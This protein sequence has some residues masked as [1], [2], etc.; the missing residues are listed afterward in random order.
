MIQR[1]SLML[2]IS[3]AWHIVW[4][5]R[6]T[7]SFVLLIVVIRRRLYKQLPLFTLHTFWIALA[8]LAVV[9][10]VY[11]SF[12][13]GEQYFA[14]IVI[15]NG[16]EAILAFAIIYQIFVQ[17]VSHYPRLR[18]WGS[19][20][21]RTMT[22]ILVVTAVALAWLVPV[23]GT[24]H[25]SVAYNVVHRTVRMLQCG[26]LLFFFLF[27]GY[28]RLSWRSRPFGIALGF[29]IL[30]GTSLAINAIRAQIGSLA[31]TPS[32][33]AILLV[34]EL[35]YILAIAVWLYYLLAR[36]PRPPTGRDGLPQHDLATWNQELERMLEP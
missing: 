18:D 7:L 9:A 23:P 25:L 30:S 13:S 14:A 36:D 16:V 35:T 21:F 34:S 12:V 27:C 4:F 32:Q 17:R 8:G 2:S 3:L 15:S 31:W 33:L 24:S 20:A 1:G 6:V 29:S 10:M 22:L 11:A 28:F 19:S 5:T 26:Q